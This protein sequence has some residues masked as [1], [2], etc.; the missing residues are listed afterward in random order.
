MDWSC[1][2]VVLSVGSASRSARYEQI[3]WHLRGG[4]Q[5]LLLEAANLQQD[6]WKSSVTFGRPWYSS[7]VNF[8]AGK[9][10]LGRDAEALPAIALVAVDVGGAT[11]ACCLRKMSSGTARS[12]RVKES[13]AAASSCVLRSTKSKIV[14]RNLPPTAGATP[15][16]STPLL[17]SEANDEAEL[18][19]VSTAEAS[20]GS[21]GPLS[22][23][24]TFGGASNTRRDFSSTF[25]S[26]T[27]NWIA[28]D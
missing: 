17:H 24:R 19:I 22:L 4:L 28:T 5:R 2:E 11:A 18:E 13:F 12:R 1:S 7:V 20:F 26:S 25:R 27:T 15:T 10:L 8:S 16:T 3:A 21:W 6:F 23:A 9:D 14:E